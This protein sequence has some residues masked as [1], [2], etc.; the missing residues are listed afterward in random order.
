MS[1][2]TF[3]G[4]QHASYIAILIR[5][6]FNSNNNGIKNN[7]CIFPHFYL[8][9]IYFNLENQTGLFIINIYNPKPAF[10]NQPMSFLLHT[11]SLTKTQN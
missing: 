2:W 6:Y 4:K 1:V 10:E 11:S 8:H 5:K 3:S 9:K 7:T